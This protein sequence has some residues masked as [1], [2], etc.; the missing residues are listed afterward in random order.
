ML[1][2]STL[3]IIALCALAALAVP[4]A[5]AARKET[6]RDVVGYFWVPERDTSPYWT[7]A[8]HRE[9]ISTLA[10]TWLS[11]GTT[12]AFNNISDSRLMRWAKRNGIRVT[13]LLANHPFKPE[14]ARPVFETDEAIRR[15][16]ALLLK[17]VSDL[18]A[19]GLN[20]DIEGVAPEDRGRYNAF[21]EALCREFHAR[22]LIVTAAVPAKTSDAPTAAWAG[23]ADY[24]FLG[25]HLDQVQLMCYDEH[26]SGG[27]PGP[28][29]SIPW[30]RKVLEYAVTLIPREK[31]VMGMPFYG[32]DWPAE[33]SAREVTA[34]RAR[35]LLENPSIRPLWDDVAKTG[36][37]TY[38]DAGGASRTVYFEDARSQ[39]E[40][41]KLAREFGVAGVAIWRLGDETPDFWPP[42]IRFRSGR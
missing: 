32:Y 30:V 18:G 22:G 25:K 28:I 26:W 20:V 14:T 1:C 7:L 34:T 5:M 16:V 12:G 6:K 13:P 31:L 17:T 27:A 37:F 42:L 36:H 33:G 35:E 21:I 19:D 15:N 11:Y 39:A 29:A 3:R 9:G 40:R 24:A 8:D 2:M 23:F 10:P 38:T 41:L 4:S